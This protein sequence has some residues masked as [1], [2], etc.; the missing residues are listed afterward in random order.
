M[1]RYP[2]R[3]IKYFIYLVYPIIF[4][5]WKLPKVLSIEEALEKSYKIIVLFSRLKDGV[6]LYIIDRLNLPFQKQDPVLR[7]KL[8]KI[9]KSNEL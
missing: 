9:M 7:G 3:I 1:F 6:F 2:C 5:I 8:I 4:R